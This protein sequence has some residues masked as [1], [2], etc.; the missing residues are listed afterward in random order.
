MRVLPA[1]P[2]GRLT[3]RLID[4]SIALGRDDTRLAP[5]EA[6]SFTLE[7]TAPAAG[8]LTLELVG[9]TWR[10][11]EKDFDYHELDGRYVRGRV[12]VHEERELPV[13]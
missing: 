3:T 6:R 10:M 1:R 11:H 8:P 7:L 5:R 12:F 13:D 4:R 2:R 9:A